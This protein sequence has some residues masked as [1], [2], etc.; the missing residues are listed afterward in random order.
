MD[1]SRREKLTRWALNPDTKQP[2][3]EVLIREQRLQGIGWRGN[4]ADIYT[5]QHTLVETLNSPDRVFEGLRFDDD[6]PRSCNSQGWLCYAKRPARRYNS[7]GG[8]DA[9]PKNRIFLV[10]VNADRVVY[11]WAWEEADENA[12]AHGECFPSGYA[13]RFA[14]QVYPVER[15]YQG[16]KYDRYD[17]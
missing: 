12:L 11:N 13:K 14:K 7:R 5:A 17:R 3:L 2:D 10:F 16:E 8:A 6:E 4:N 1:G 15:V 9:T